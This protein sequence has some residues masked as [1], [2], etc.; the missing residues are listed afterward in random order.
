ML[1]RVRFGTAGFAGSLCVRGVAPERILFVGRFTPEKGLHVLI[2]AFERL[3]RRWDDL[4]LDIV[5]GG[6]ATVSDFMPGLL[7]DPRI[8][9]L[10]DFYR[11]RDYAAWLRGRVEKAGLAERVRFLGTLSR[12]PLLGV[13]RAATVLA[14]PALIEP[15]GMVTAEAMAAGLPVVA[16]RVGGLPEVVQHGR[17][18]LLVP[19]GDP[20]ALAEAI[21]SLLADPDR[22]RRY[23]AAARQYARTH[24][25]WDRVAERVREVYNVTAAAR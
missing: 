25:R 20:E 21:A 11:H 17:T 9:P 24:F 8:A 1:D 15:F 5:G 22:R 12:E 13:Y 19:P 16:S 10:A 23:A 4:T 14:H 3:A 6:K 2:D 7:R 18:G